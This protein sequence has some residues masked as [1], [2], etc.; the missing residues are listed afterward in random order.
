MIGAR[1]AIAVL[2]ATLISQ[3]VTASRIDCKHASCEFNIPEECQKFTNVYCNLKN[4][5]RGQ[6]NLTATSF[7]RLVRDIELRN[8]KE[9]TIERDTIASLASL[10]I[11]KLHNIETL[12]LQPRSLARE[13]G[14]GQIAVVI[15]EVNNLDVH[16][17]TF[18]GWENSKS[19]VTIEK[20]ETCRIFGMAIASTHLH[21]LKMHQVTSL[22]LGHGAFNAKSI[23]DQVTMTEMKNLSIDTGAFN[24]S[25]NISTM[26]LEDVETLSLN[27][28][29]FAPGTSIQKM[30]IERSPNLHI[31]PD[32]IKADIDT[33]ALKHVRMATC[34]KHTFGSTIKSLS[35]TDSSINKTQAN[36]ISAT[37]K[38]MKLL[39][40]TSTIGHI[41]PLAIHGDIE[42]LEIIDSDLGTVAEGGVTVNVANFSVIKSTFGEVSG[43][44]LKVHATEQINLKNCTINILKTDAFVL[45][46][47]DGKAED[48]IR[49]ED[50]VVVA[51]EN[52]SMQFDHRQSILMLR[53][54][55][56]IPCTCFSSDMTK[57]LGL[58]DM[59]NADDARIRR[60]ISPP[61]VRCENNGTW[62]NLGE[63]QLEF[64]SDPSTTTTLTSTTPDISVTI[65][66]NTGTPGEYY[67]EAGF[68]QTQVH[69]SSAWV[70]A[71]LTPKASGIAVLA[72][73][74]LS[75][76][77]VV[78]RTTRGLARKARSKKWSPVQKKSPTL[79]EFRNLSTKGGSLPQRRSG[80]RTPYRR[81]QSESEAT[82]VPDKRL[83]LPGQPMDRQDSRNQHP[84]RDLRAMQVARE[85]RAP[86]VEVPLGSEV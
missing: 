48:R 58:T 35:L 86:H 29:A 42:Q 60:S 54:E 66:S 30:F 77:S 22:E 53:L 79:L 11:L 63:Y 81:S 8:I 13:N 52:G 4:R 25:V 78:G 85:M 20:L 18:S 64:C 50:L 43:R 17:D 82:I 14:T 69:I 68:D 83:V 72:P 10:E 44:A 12:T 24:S 73:D 7:P 1:L 75:H 32:S 15:R 23:I 2:T 49:V 46:D 56:G 28:A 3:P 6:V 70:A 62:P 21:S 9:L 16:R 37:Q 38:S 41:A 55:V 33:L 74:L 27:S 31:A 61:H 84:E 40:D 51:P 57:A 45:L 71:L 76:T 5:P 47:L 65:S 80:G 26:T 39:V 34:H 67:A 59:A 19:R 36:C